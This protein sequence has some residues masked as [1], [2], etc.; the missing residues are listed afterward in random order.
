MSKKDARGNGEF[1]TETIVSNC[2]ERRRL[3]GAF[4]EDSLETSDIEEVA[5]VSSSTAHRIKNKLVRKGLVEESERGVYDLT[6]TGEAMA[7]ELESFCE[8]VENIRKLEPVL[9]SMRSRESGFD[10]SLFDD[11]VITTASPTR[12]YEPARRFMDIFR[13]TDELRLVVVS[14][15]TPIFS[16]EKQRMIAEG[17][18]TEVVCP[19]SVVEV[20][21]ETVPHDIIDGLIENLTLRVHDDLPF[22]VALFDDRV[23]VAGHAE[24]GTIKVFADTADD[25]A[26]DWGEHV[27][28][29]YRSESV[30]MFERFDVEELSERFGFKPEEVLV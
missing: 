13:E 5:D 25:E 20:S 24:D 6:R 10:P 16:E 2:V 21:M 23:G 7:R 26:Y 4:L 3:L 29:R 1:D 18:Q 9:E 28:E 17:K 30:E 15:A 19:E 12:P 27:Y 14:T 8:R 22:S 11:G